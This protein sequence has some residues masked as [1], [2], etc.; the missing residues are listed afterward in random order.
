VKKLG[1]CLL[2]LGFIFLFSQSASSVEASSDPIQKEIRRF[3]TAIVKGDLYEIRNLLVQ[4][5]E[6][7]AMKRKGGYTP[8]HDSVL[9]HQEK[10]AE[11]LIAKGANVNAKDDHGRTPLYYASS[12]KLDAIADMLRARGAQ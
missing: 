7:L 9:F 2:L 11:L 5:P 12:R 3:R 8:L 6:F 1:Y 10:V 4:H